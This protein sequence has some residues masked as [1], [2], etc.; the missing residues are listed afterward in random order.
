MVNARHTICF[1]GAREFG[2]RVDIQLWNRVFKSGWRYWTML[3]DSFALES[4]IWKYLHVFFKSP[5]VLH[6][7]VYPG[8]RKQTFLGPVYRISMGTKVVN[9]SPTET[10]PGERTRVCRVVTQ[11]TRDIDPIVHRQCRNIKPISDQRPTPA[12]TTLFTRSRPHLG[13]YSTCL[14]N[15]YSTLTQ[16]MTSAPYPLW[17]FIFSSRR[18]RRWDGGSYGFRLRF[19]CLFFCL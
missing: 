9:T 13:R 4:F 15:V 2:V 6:Q 10:V 11:R 18:H 5:S 1:V 17:S 14:F 16:G 8:Q 19:F 7:F 3:M 12:A